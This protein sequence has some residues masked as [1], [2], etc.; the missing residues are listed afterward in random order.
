MDFR[1]ARAGGGFHVATMRAAVLACASAV[2]VF[3]GC[4]QARST[5]SVEAPR[6]SDPE[7]ADQ[8]A[9][10][11][12]NAEVEQVRRERLD[13][14]ESDLPLRDDEVAM[15][16]DLLALK[17]VVLPNA[18][19]SDN[20]AIALSGLISL[21]ELVLGETTI[22]DRGLARLGSLPLR[23]LNLKS[24]LV[25]DRGLDELGMRTKL[26]LLR[27]GRSEITDEGLAAIGRFSS[28]RYLILQNARITG[29]GLPR[30]GGLRDLESLYLHGNPLTGE[31][32]DE[33]RRTH[34][35]LH[36]DW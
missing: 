22:S 31:G 21:E 30:L 4:G 1:F 14:I 6:Q 15:L 25:T 33:L 32:V 3:A 7:P 5:D 23:V 11:Q 16:A 13:S 18:R 17:K 9:R 10:A 24:C 20:A 19:V 35:K 28:L 8:I 26:E 2:I 34:P 12:W 29:R 36:P 27:F